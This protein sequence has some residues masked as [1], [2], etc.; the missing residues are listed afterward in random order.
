MGSIGFIKAV[1]GGVVAVSLGATAVGV[2]GAEIGTKSASQP[3]G[4]TVTLHEVTVLDDGLLAKLDKADS[5][6]MV[7]ALRASRACQETNGAA[8]PG[9]NAAPERGPLHA[10][11]GTDTA[12][13]FVCGHRGGASGRTG[14]QPGAQ[15][16]LK[17]MLC[18]GY[19]PGGARRSLIQASPVGNVVA[20]FNEFKQ[21]V[22]RGT[23]YIL[24]ELGIEDSPITS[25]DQATLDETQDELDSAAS[26]AEVDRGTAELLSQGPDAVRAKKEERLRQQ[27]EEKFRNDAG[28]AGGSSTTESADVGSDGIRG[29]G[30]DSAF[31]DQFCQERKSLLEEGEDMLTKGE[32]EDS[33]CDDP[34]VN[35]AADS[36]TNTIAEPTRG[37]VGH[38]AYEAPDCNESTRRDAQSVLE[39]VRS[40][41][42]NVCEQ[43]ISPTGRPCND[44]PFSGDD[45][46]QHPEVI[47]DDIS[48]DFCRQDVCQ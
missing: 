19:Q 27:T 30:P 15:N 7:E 42:S 37:G 25:E 47:V 38:V 31:L 43:G 6:R 22:E 40:G 9:V 36:R 48:D 41:D 35:P 8:V 28:A 16:P 46:G 21:T 23:Q 32:R 2:A 44:E 11:A 14:G 5:L 33:D 20:A 12:M 26:F 1:V 3:S 13:R 45:L 18:E 39:G 4:N 34:V 17:A 10:S 29:G 24:W